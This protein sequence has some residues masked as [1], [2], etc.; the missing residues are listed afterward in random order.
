[1]AAELQRL[2][3]GRVRVA[4]TPTQVDLLRCLEAA[5]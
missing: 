2:G 4:A 5:R 1:V 3:L